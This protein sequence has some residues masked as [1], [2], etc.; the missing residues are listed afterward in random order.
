MGN[1]ITKANTINVE[2]EKAQSIDAS[3]SFETLTP[4]PTPLGS[5]QCVTYKNEIL[6]CGGLGTRDCYSYHLHKNEYKLICSY[7]KNIEL[8]GHC[9]VKLVNNNTN[10]ITLLSFGGRTKHALTM[11]YMSIWKG[12]DETEISI[13]K[14]KHCNKWIPL[15]DNDNNPIQIGEHGDIYQ[16]A[17]ALIGGSNN[18][19][20][21]I[22]HYPMSIAVFDL[23]T[24]QFIKRDILPISKD[25]WIR[26]HCFASK[27]TSWPSIIN[28]N[29]RIYEMLL[30]Y[31]NSGLLIG[32]DEGN[33][34]FTFHDMR[35]CTTIRSVVSYGYTCIN[36]FILLF[37][38]DDDSKPGFSNQVYKYS[39]SEKQWMKFEQTLP[40]SLSDCTAVLSND[41]TYV[42]ILGGFDGEKKLSIHIKTK[43]N[44]W[45]NE[46]EI[47]K[48]WIIH[49]EEK[50]CIE[51]IKAELHDMKG[52]FAIKKL[53]VESTFKQ[54][55]NKML[56]KCKINFVIT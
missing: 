42:H 47:E 35:V 32:Y 21:F 4:L 51:E 56:N 12:D 48:Q 41:G 39:M 29:K 2:T 13:K 20:L 55:N 22:S 30:F 23:N 1:R 17:R 54:L 38:G 14:T 6:I 45:M 49:E 46:T 28:D 27:S 31:K 10:D 9:V 16:G 34:A 50:K 24:F 26:Y 8:L 15:T 11:S 37:G 53:K 18:H 33:N 40:I 7:P 44:K 5:S 19:L 43:V 36:D 3:V 52:D 25:N